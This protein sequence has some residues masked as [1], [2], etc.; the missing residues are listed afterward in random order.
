[1]ERL[2]AD[3]GD[4]GTKAYACGDGLG[5][6]FF[7]DGEGVNFDASSLE[8][9]APTLT[10]SEID[11]RVIAQADK[12]FGVVPRRVDCGSSTDVRSGSTLRCT[13]T[14]RSR[15]SATFTATVTGGQG[16]FTVV[17]S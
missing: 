9:Q 11:A 7:P 13:I 16:S 14:L 2:A 1:M 15:R 5:A 3:V 4:Y 8:T 17:L 10:A 12:Q 6:M